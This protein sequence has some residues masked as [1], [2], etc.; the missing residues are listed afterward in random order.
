MSGP[1]G[2]DAVTRAGAA[3]LLS[4]SASTVRRLEGKELHPTVGADGVRRFE[5]AE[6]EALAARRGNGSANGGTVDAAV[7]P[8]GGSATSADGELAARAFELFTAGRS[9][10]EV[11]IALREP[12][13]AIVALFKQWA[14]LT[15]MIVVY[16][17]AW[18]RARAWLRACRCARFTYPC[19]TCG[20]S[21]QAEPDGEWEAV[22]ESGVLGEWGH[23]DCAASE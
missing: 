3:A 19:A 21:I 8:S 10:A 15:G 17:D 9:P 14:A 13:D 6:V 1:N 5:R 23:A 18:E 2:A 20:E 16:R 12:P 7:A 4:V 11:V 22:L